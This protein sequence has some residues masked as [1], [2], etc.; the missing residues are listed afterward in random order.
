MIFKKEEIMV[1]FG[2]RSVV[3]GQSKKTLFIAEAM[4][5]V[6]EGQTPTMED[7]SPLSP[8]INMVF[9]TVES[10][11]TLIGLLKKVKDHLLKSQIEKE[12]F[13][14]LKEEIKKHSAETEEAVDE[15]LADCSETCTCCRDD[16]DDSESLAGD[17]EPT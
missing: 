5:S 2:T 17:E 8:Q 1:Q 16:V 15:Y 12:M 13:E 11:D 6:P 3:L 9:E 4:E 10:V 7:V 14:R